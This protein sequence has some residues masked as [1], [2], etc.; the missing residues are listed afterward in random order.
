MAGG[1]RKSP[2]DP[3]GP[4]PGRGPG[5]L[6][7]GPEILSYAD[8]P[9]AYS[10]VGHSPNE[11]VASPDDMHRFVRWRDL[12]AAERRRRV[13]ERRV[14]WMWQQ[15]GK[16]P[17]TEMLISHTKLDEAHIREALADP[18]TIA[19]LRRDG[20]ISPEAD[21]W[22][23][24]TGERV[25]LAGRQLDAVRRVFERVDPDDPASWRGALG[26]V[27][28]TVREW[29]GWM[30]DPLFA[31][32]VRDAGARLFGDH[33]HSVDIA[34][35]RNAVAGDTAAIKLVLEVTGRIK[36]DR[37]TV[38]AGMLLARVIEV[39][40]HHLSEAQ[41]QPVI[42]DLENIAGVLGS[43]AQAALPNSPVRPGPVIDQAGAPVAGS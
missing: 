38:D 8:V 17:T 20:A 31:S 9:L 40:V 16:L 43:P 4:D 7:N 25:M 26:E 32:F 1:K 14:L 27:G 37:N 6:R 30:R 2:L 5:R 36:A 19:N 13:V 41:L 21:D 18:I 3:T 42:A 24:A 34:L 15:A 11:Q 23:E 10:D 22:E 39:L 28:V 35:L 29:N 12:P 33:A